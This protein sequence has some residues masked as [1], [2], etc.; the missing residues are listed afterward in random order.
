[1]M[2]VYQVR[3]FSRFAPCTAACLCLGTVLCGCDSISITA[4]RAAPRGPQQ[5]GAPH[6]RAVRY[7]RWGAQSVRATQ[8]TLTDCREGGRLPGGSPHSSQSGVISQPRLVFVRRTFV[9]R[10]FLR[11]YWQPLFVGQKIPDP[12]E[13]TIA[14]TEL[15]PRPEPRIAA[16]VTDGEHDWRCRQNIFQVKH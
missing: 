3:I 8:N 9:G 11:R 14:I 5:Q 4:T 16:S 12:I 10:G 2:I 1:M 13:P 7:I 15:R 6:R